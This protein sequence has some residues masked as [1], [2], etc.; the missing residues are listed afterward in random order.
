MVS[1]AAPE[2][3]GIPLAGAAAAETVGVLLASAAE[4][5][6]HDAIET[7]ENIVDGLKKTA[8][9]PPYCHDVPSP[10]Q[11]VL[12]PIQSICENLEGFCGCGGSRKG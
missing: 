12:E 6:V 1:A 2:T 3:V 11:N 9:A 4:A 5:A 8:P 7:I 10:S